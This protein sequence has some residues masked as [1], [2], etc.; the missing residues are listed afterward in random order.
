MVAIPNTFLFRHYVCYGHCDARIL[1]N[2]H[3][4]C[5]SRYQL[6]FH[7]PKVLYHA[8]QFFGGHMH[9]LRHI[10]YIGLIWYFNLGT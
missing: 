6:E 9:I 8:K 7:T 5:L 3:Q 1:T 4:V 10:P 2:T